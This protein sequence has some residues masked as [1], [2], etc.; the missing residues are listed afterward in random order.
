MCTLSHLPAPQVTLLVDA[1]LMVKQHLYGLDILLVDGVQ[2]R[3]LGLDLVLEQQLDHL[4]VLVVDA[5]EERSPAQRVDA[6]DIDAIPGAFQH[7]EHLQSFPQTID[8]PFLFL[9]ELI[10]R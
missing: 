9:W 7:P 4:K 3:V 10:Y 8:I 6:I 2:E 5:H 1:L